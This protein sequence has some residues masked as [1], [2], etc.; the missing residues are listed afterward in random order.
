MVAIDLDGEVYAVARWAGL[1][2]K[3][4]VAR[5]GDIGPLPGVTEMQERLAM[6]VQEKLTNLA[7]TAREQFAR[8]ANELEAR[9]VAMVQQ[10][11]L[12][13]AELEQKQDN[14]RI[15]ESRERGKRFRKGFLGLWDRVTGKHAVLRMQ[16]EQEAETARKRDLGEKDG[17]VRNQLV[18]RR[19]LQ[20]EIQLTRRQE[21]KQLARLLRRSRYQEQSEDRSVDR[22]PLD[23]QRDVEK[24]GLDRRHRRV[25]P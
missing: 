14:R 11:R 18:E 19:E 17:L 25:E 20:G 4:V 15:V 2:S 10:H 5:V 21:T 8:A 24:S 16:N 1:R 23:S 13:R 22:N 3:Q 7:A 12:A 9:R 6:L